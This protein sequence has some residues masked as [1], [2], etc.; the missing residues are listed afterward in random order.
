MFLISREDFYYSQYCEKNVIRTWCTMWHAIACQIGLNPVFNFLFFNNQ[1]MITFVVFHTEKNR[2][3]KFSLASLSYRHKFV[4]SAPSNL[5]KGWIGKK[6]V[7]TLPKGFAPMQN[8]GF[9][10]LC[11]SFYAQQQQQWAIENYC[12]IMN[13]LGLLQYYTNFL[14]FWLS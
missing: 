8:A 4:V 1:P 9:S 12:F 5:Q 3:D 7:F 10:R 14:L 2:F 13:L 11:F 6:W